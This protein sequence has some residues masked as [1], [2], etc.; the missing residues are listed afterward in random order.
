MMGRRDPQRS[1]FDARTLPHRVPEDSFYGQMAAVAD[2]LFGDEDLEEMYCPDNGR[3][4]EPPP[5]MSGVMLLQLHDDVSDREA[6]DRTMFDQ[7]WKV[8]LGLPLDYEGFHPTNLTNFRKRL[9]E[10]G[11]ERY[12]FDRFIAMGRAAGFIP[13]KV[14]LLTDTTW[15][16]GAGAVQNT[17][18]LIRKSM[19][20]ILRDLGYATPS[21]RRG[22]S[23]QVRTL[24]A[25]YIDKNRKAEIDWSDPEQRAAQLKVLVQDAEMVL[26]LAAEHSDDTEVQTSAWLLT[27]ILGDDIVDDDD[28][29]PQ[30]GE[31]TAPDRIISM[32][33][34]DMRHGRKSRAH[35]FDGFK[36]SV[37][38]DLTSD[39]ILDIAD[40]TAA[41]GDGQH[42]MPTV[43]RTEAQTGATVERVVGDGAYGSGHNLEACAQHT[44]H[45]IDLLTPRRRPADPEVHK[46][47]FRIDREAKTATCPQGITVSG[48]DRH[49]RQ[50]R[51]FLL[52][53]FPRDRCEACPLFE[54]CVRS[55]THG[56]SVRTS[57]YEAYLQ[58]QREQQETAEFLV[59]YPQR[60][61]VERIIA[62]LVYRGLRRTRYLG[63]DK[64]QLQRLW[65]AAV[66][67]LKR[68]LRLA[69]TQAIDLRLLL[70][71]QRPCWA[72]PPPSAYAATGG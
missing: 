37:S 58:A 11:K 51:P 33:D 10:H 4:S 14:T 19:R 24:V 60:S 55:K 68:L 36:V 72:G 28:G 47:A 65:L 42:L 27:K 15:A 59:L 69:A 53:H 30:I 29:N 35:R 50:G 23:S 1:L 57:P 45:P 48:R 43:R 16:K 2:D 26:D 39:M 3:P 20:K 62:E 32:T 18:T 63:Q 6:V 12:A 56:R 41:G 52:F 34:P 40:V 66:V 5:L 46:W 13:D 54:R 21:K 9:L 70:R 8:A 31:G 61:R 25:T 64:R 67:N 22:L 44:D 71:H 17:Y 38:S 7:R 49:D